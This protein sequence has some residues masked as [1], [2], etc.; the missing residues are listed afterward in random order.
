MRLVPINE[1]WKKTGIIQLKINSGLTLEYYSHLDGG[2]TL[3]KNDFVRCVRQFGSKK[4]YSRGYEWCSGTG[5]IGFELV[6]FDICDHIVFSDYY[7]LAIESCLSNAEKNLL[8]QKVTGYIS[9]SITELP[10]IE[11]W[12]LVIGN[13]PHSFGNM[14][15]ALAEIL[16]YTENEIFATNTL[17]TLSDE[18]YNTHRDFFHNIHH[19]VTDDADIFIYEPMITHKLDI[20]M[21]ESK[22]KL[23]GIYPMVDIFESIKNNAP[24]IDPEIHK[25]GKIYHFKL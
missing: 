21:K 2:G 25:A 4:K 7:P 3:M 1:E 19:R 17:R 23:V 24:W 10:A 16:D 11:K 15:S 18:N 6:G 20:I 22:L 13:P 5:F 9:R 8:S 12:D 14:E